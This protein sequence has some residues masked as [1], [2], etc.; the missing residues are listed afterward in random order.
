MRFGTRVMCLYC[1]AP[2]AYEMRADRKGR[3]YFLCSVCGA[4]TFLRGQQSLAGP[5]ML[6]GPLTAALAN[7]DAEAARVLIQDIAENTKR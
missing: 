1:L 2:D 7:N 6:W 3:P 4:R 5:T